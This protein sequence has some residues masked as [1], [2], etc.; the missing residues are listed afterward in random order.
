[1]QDLKIPED[2]VD[3]QPFVKMIVDQNET[4]AGS[5]TFLKTSQINDIKSLD[6]QT[7]REALIRIGEGKVVGD[8]LELSGLRARLGS[9]QWHH[10]RWTACTG[11]HGHAVALCFTQ[12][13][14]MLCH[15]AQFLDHAKFGVDTERH[16]VE[17]IQF[18][19]S[20][21]PMHGCKPRLCYGV[22]MLKR[23]S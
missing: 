1:M 20:L 3:E 18:L 22:P 23:I 13:V 19:H 8:Q 6:P 17:E 12:A 21:S 5:K 15:R 2:V 10:H 11:D 16:T 9:D 7:S 4:P 14:A